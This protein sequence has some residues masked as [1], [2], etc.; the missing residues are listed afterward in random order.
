M[1]RFQKIK[2]LD[3]KTRNQLRYIL[4]NPTGNVIF[5]LK[6][7]RSKLNKRQVKIVDDILSSPIPVKA[8]RH[9]N[10]FPSRPA[11]VDFLMPQQFN[12]IGDIL[13]RIEANIKANAKKLEQ[14]ICIFRSIDLAY[15]EKDIKKCRELVLLCIE[16]CGWSHAILRKLILI[17]ESGLLN[18]DNEIES[19]IQKAGLSTNAIVVASLIHIFSKD[20]NYLTIKRS[21]LN[22]SDQGVVNR[23][24][25]LL[26]RLPVNPI[27][28]D[29]NDFVGLL[30]GAESCSL[31]DAII[32]AKFNTHLFRIEEYPQILNISEQ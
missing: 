22:I 13:N 26:T 31:I 20:Q 9:Q 19:L 14:I 15:S 12:D 28:T 6:K 10:P 23:Y 11:F 27:S 1:N 21:I 25:R 3:E 17:R 18:E 16:Q 24:S 5:D 30:T 8:T 7:L 2:L 4:S 32:V 29:T